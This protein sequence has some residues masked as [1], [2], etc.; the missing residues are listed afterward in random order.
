M[1]EVTPSVKIDES[2]I[3]LDFIRASGPGDQN[4][5]GDLIG[6]FGRGLHL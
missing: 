5:N 3:Q 2:E 1:I 4:F 6:A